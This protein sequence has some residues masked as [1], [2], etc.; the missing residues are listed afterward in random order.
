[1]LTIDAI[2]IRYSNEAQSS[3]CLSCGSAIEYASL[4]KGE[5]VLDLGSGRGNDV[6]KATKYIG[7]EGKAIGVDVTPEMIEIAKKN[8]EKLNVKN[9]EFLLGDIENLPLEDN[10]VDV[11]ISNC[12]I[13]HAKNK[14]NVYKEIFRVLKPG[15]RFVVSDIIAEKELPDD[16]KNDPEA[17]AQC[18][19]GAIPKEEYFTSIAAANFNEIEILEESEPYEKG[20]ENVLVRS[21]TIK[22]Y[23][24]KE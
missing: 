17:W 15:G 18:Y 3:C 21:I 19:G 11:V 5:V 13:N 9:V 2:K 23:K 20:K 6:L 10:S 1:M 14:E 24:N 4:Q 12:V 22:G 8:A 7:K 16:V